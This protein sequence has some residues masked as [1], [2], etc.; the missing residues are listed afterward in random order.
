MTRADQDAVA[1]DLTIKLTT[2]RLLSLIGGDTASDGIES[3]GD[4]AVLATLLGVLDP[5]DDAFSIVTP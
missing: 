1:D 2:L 5:G 3:D 4:E